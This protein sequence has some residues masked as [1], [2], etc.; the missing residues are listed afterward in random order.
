[1][2]R[3]TRILVVDRPAEAGPLARALCDAG[4]E[5]ATCATAQEAIAT[6]AT[7]RPDLVVLE[8]RVHG[9]DDGAGTGPPAPR[10][11]RSNVG[12]LER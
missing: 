12:V 2:Q 8:M 11:R 6:A 4:Y 3:L 9:G 5:M 1:M 10:R 7:F